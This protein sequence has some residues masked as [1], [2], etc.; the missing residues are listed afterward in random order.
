M[1]DSNSKSDLENNSEEGQN[2]DTTTSSP[3]QDQEEISPDEKLSEETLLE[4]YF[5]CSICKTKHLR[6][7]KFDQVEEL[8]HHLATEHFN[9][10]ILKDLKEQLLKN[11]V[12]P[13]TNCESL[14]NQLKL[15][16]DHF[17]FSHKEENF[18]MTNAINKCQT[19]YQGPF[20]TFAELLKNLAFNHSDSIDKFTTKMG[21][22]ATMNP[23]TDSNED[24]LL[25]GGVLDEEQVCL[26]FKF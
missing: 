21:L 1:A 4:E 24:V 26:H 8:R 13:M 6:I 10:L 19:C 16:E 20:P 2:D 17:G 11:P 3:I 14:F 22:S 12:C 25:D 23:I 9:E 15:V 18:D 7:L 5:H